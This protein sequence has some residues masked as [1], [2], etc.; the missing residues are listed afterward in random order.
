MQSIDVKAF[1]A[2]MANLDMCYLNNVLC[3]CYTEDAIIV[4]HKLNDDI[5]T[6]R[7][8]RYSS[9]WFYVKDRP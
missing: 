6:I 8:D 4:W 5:G 9:E 1:R 2:D 7:A 3:V